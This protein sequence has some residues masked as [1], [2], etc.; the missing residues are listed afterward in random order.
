RR[1]ADDC[2]FLGRM[3]RP[4]Q[5]DSAAVGRDRTRKG[6]CSQSSESKRGR[7]SESFVEVQYSCDSGA[8]FLQERST[9]RS[10]HRS[11][12]QEGSAQPLGSIG[13]DKFSAARNLIEKA[14]L[15]FQAGAPR[16]PTKGICAR[17]G[18]NPQPLAPEA[19]A[20]SS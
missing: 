15:Q 20:L 12:Q 10:S 11:Y 9:T 2:R 13:V 6:G 19:N 7:Q 18:S 5:N 16:G 14:A 3:V 1:Q 8:A 4:L 17:R